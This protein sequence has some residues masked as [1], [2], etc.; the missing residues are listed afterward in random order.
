MSGINDRIY[1]KIYSYGFIGL[2]PNL[3]N[4]EVVLSL[5][6]N[7]AVNIVINEKLNIMI[8]GVKF[9]NLYTSICYNY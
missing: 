3:I 6:T 8:P 1:P 7:V 9:F 4:N 2:M 5:A